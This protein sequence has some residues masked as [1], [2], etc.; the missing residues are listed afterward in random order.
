MQISNHFFLA[1]P[2]RRFKRVV[3]TI[4][5]QLLSTHDQ[6]SVQALAGKA[7][8][9]TQTPRALTHQLRA[10]FT[11]DLSV[12]SLPRRE[13]RSAVAS[14]QHPF[15][16]ELPAFREWV[17][18]GREGTSGRRGKRKWRQR[19]RKRP[20]EGGFGQRQDQTPLVV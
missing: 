14:A 11:F 7:A 8:T 18:A 4:Q 1:G 9:P 3:E 12:G 17:R 19:H 13:E 5:A 15:A 20:T 6:P 16:S 10:F 2:S